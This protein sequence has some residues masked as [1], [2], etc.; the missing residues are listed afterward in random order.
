MLELLK[1]NH[2]QQVWSGKA[3]R[4]DMER[5][6]RLRDRLAFPA[7][8]LFPHRL[9]H[10]PLPRNHPQRLVMSSPSFDSFAEAQ[11]GQ[12]SGAAMTMC[13]RGR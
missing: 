1:Q 6:R 3:P 5:R 8:E 13:S 10:L 12:L 11:R 2:G 7:R 9:D 4:R